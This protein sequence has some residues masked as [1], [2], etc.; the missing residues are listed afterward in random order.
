MYKDE[1]VVQVCTFCGFIF[2]GGG[3]GGGRWLIGTDEQ[4]PSINHEGN[5][6]RVVFVAIIMRSLYFV[7]L[8]KII[9]NLLYLCLIYQ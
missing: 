3:W 5:L 4:S 1:E 8:E 2:V 6:A 7:T 9:K